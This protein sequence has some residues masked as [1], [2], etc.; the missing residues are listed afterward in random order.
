MPIRR[1][2]ACSR[3]LCSLR[4]MRRGS[5]IVRSMCVTSATAPGEERPFPTDCCNY[6]S[7][8]GRGGLNIG[9]W[10]SGVIL[11]G[12]AVHNRC[13]DDRTSFWR[14]STFPGF[15]PAPEVHSTGENAINGTRR[16][17]GRAVD[18]SQFPFSRES[19]SL[20]VSL[21]VVIGPGLCS[22]RLDARA[23]RQACDCGFSAAERMDGLG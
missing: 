1:I 23:H 15:L 20:V 21:S 19:A 18:H 14:G 12:A 9:S 8:L 6:V 5:S 4:M 11:T 13:R 17:R 2:S 7:I 10:W 3:G 22:A 16:I